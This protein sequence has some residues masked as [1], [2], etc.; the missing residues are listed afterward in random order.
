M[1]LTFTIYH[2]GSKH[3]AVDSLGSGVDHVFPKPS[4]LTVESDDSGDKTRR[5]AQRPSDID[6]RSSL[7][8]PVPSPMEE[9]YI[10]KA[11]GTYQT[12]DQGR[13]LPDIRL[14]L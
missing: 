13:H 3:R 10:G 1:L 2:L 9:Y 5:L 12:L 11:Q 6:R 4:L 8:E 7:H 14:Y